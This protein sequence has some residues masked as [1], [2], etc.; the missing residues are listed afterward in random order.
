M[1]IRS[2]SQ[3]P[4]KQLLTLGALALAVALTTAGCGEGAADVIDSGSGSALPSGGG[5]TDASAVAVFLD[6]EFHGELLADSCFNPHG[7]I[8]N[9]V[10]YTVGQ[11]NGDDSVGRLDKLDVTNVETESVDGD[12]KISYQA[13]MPVAWNRKNDV[14][15]RYVLK[16][17]ADM[18][19]DSIAAFATKYEHSCLASGAHDVT[20]GIF[21]YYY[22]PARYSCSLDAADIVEIEALVFPSAIQTAG[23]Y[24]E[25]HE[26][27]K[28]DVFEVVAVFG[29]YEDNAT[30]GDAGIDAYNRFSRDIREHL[31]FY[32]PALQP[33]EIPTNP[34]VDMPDITIEANLEDGRKI[35][36]VML[37]VDS[38][39]SADTAF[40]ARYESLTPSADFIVYNGHA[41][42]GANIRKLARKGKWVEGQYAIVFMNGCDTYAY[43]DSALADAHAQV[44]PDDPEGTKTMDIVANAMPSF[45]R[46]MSGATLAL[47]THLM[48][49]KN[50]RTYEQIFTKIDSAEVVL[51]SGEH[52]N[53]YYPGYDGDEPPPSPDSGTWEGMHETGSVAKDET[54][55]YE[56]PVLAPGRYEFSMDGSGDADLYVR[57]GEAPTFDVY[58]CRPWAPGS[59]EVCEV[60]LDAAAPVH[61]MV[62]GWDAQ[63][64]FTLVG[65]LTG[66]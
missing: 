57:V 34:G 18:R 32:S 39:G 56:T 10:L 31:K 28:D 19:H 41:G 29:K 27:W 44:N 51:V 17:P 40:W 58:D 59:A 66:E 15:E 14:P 20:A 9:Q 37:L 25:Y 38:V 13:R 48:D 54:L 12:C 5:K 30:S 1:S 33:L 43:V 7:Q 46:S 62:A 22:R 47:V 35:R 61:V 8:E 45:F 55:S 60:R 64:E 53:V 21:W 24:P 4:S 16:L 3:D 11:L 63:S 50:P 23:K 26:I 2:L 49:W 42:L 6:F 65:E 36:V 52:D